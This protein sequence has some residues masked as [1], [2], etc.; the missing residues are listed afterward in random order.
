MQISVLKLFPSAKLFCAQAAATHT[1]Q[2]RFSARGAFCS[3]LEKHHNPWHP[4]GIN[5][6]RGLLVT[7]SGDF[8]SGGEHSFGDRATTVLCVE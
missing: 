4:G 3:N 6:E 1:K 2:E 8:N 5:C 7:G